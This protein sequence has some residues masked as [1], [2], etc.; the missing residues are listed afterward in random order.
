MIVLLLFILILFTLCNCFS[1]VSVIVFNCFLVNFLLPAAFCPPKTLRYSFACCA[2]VLP[3]DCAS[4]GDSESASAS[5]TAASTS[6]TAASASFIAS[7][8]LFTASSASFIASFTASSAFGSSAFSSSIP[9]GPL[10]WSSCVY[11]CCLRRL[12][13]DSFIPTTSFSFSDMVFILV[14]ASFTASSAFLTSSFAFSFSFNLF[15]ASSALS[16]RSS[17]FF[18]C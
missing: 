9:P 5:F 2:A 16:T 4:T 17:N 10:A 7:S 12:L 3:T 14:L 11:G 15:T 18:F 13:I 1:S 6:F 8:A